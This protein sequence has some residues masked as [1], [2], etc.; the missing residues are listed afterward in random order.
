MAGLG[1]AEANNGKKKK[2][3]ILDEI[4]KRQMP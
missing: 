4:V 1:V 3:T 2:E